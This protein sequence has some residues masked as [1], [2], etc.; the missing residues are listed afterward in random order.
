VNN[1]SVG[2]TAFGYQPISSLSYWFIK[3]PY[4]YVSLVASKAERIAVVAKARMM[5][6]NLNPLVALTSSMLSLIVPEVPF[7]LLKE[8]VKF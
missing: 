5:H 6:E 2:W 4:P 8:P 7:A 1:A 3:Q